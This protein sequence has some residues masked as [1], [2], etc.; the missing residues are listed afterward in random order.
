MFDNFLHLQ[1]HALEIIVA[2]CDALL[3]IALIKG[4]SLATYNLGLAREM[5]AVHL[6]ARLHIR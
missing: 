6:L 3:R 2:V 4:A 5:F 1:Q